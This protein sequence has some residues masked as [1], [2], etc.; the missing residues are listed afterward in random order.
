MPADKQRLRL[1]LMATHSRDQLD[2]ALAAI[3]R[4]GREVGLI[5]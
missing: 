1:S 3:A 2:G 5:G 4:V